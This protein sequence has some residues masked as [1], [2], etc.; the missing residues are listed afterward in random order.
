MLKKVAFAVLAGS[1]VFAAQAAVAE[2]TQFDIG[3]GRY[4]GASALPFHPTGSDQTSG[5]TTWTSG[6]MPAAAP[7]ALERTHAGVVSAQPAP[8]N[9]PG[10]YFN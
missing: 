7:Q 1:L 8:Y 10:G 5:A 4:L 3:G 9:V 2:D 6:D